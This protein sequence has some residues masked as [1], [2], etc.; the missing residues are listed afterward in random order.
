MSRTKWEP[1]YVWLLLKDGKLASVRVL[2][3]NE[4]VNLPLIL[5]SRSIARNVRKTLP[6]PETY[7]IKQFPNRLFQYQEAV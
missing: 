1:K 7:T 6:N 4:L 3:G 5:C 2:F